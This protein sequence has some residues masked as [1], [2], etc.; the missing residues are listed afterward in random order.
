MYHFPLT[1]FVFSKPGSRLRFKATKP[2]SSLGEQNKSN[3]P[4]FVPRRLNL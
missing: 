3:F 2:A 1:M 4:I